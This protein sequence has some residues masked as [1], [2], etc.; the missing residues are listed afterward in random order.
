[1]MDDYSIKGRAPP[2]GG[3]GQTGARA[4]TV[5]AQRAAERA[6]RAE[7]RPEQG[8]VESDLIDVAHA[9]ARVAHL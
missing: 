8:L 4:A 7:E 6:R 2:D 1:M 3:R 5:A 9:D